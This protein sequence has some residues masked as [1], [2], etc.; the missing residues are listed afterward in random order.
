MKDEIKMKIDSTPHIVE[1]NGKKYKMIKVV[2]SDKPHNDRVI[3]RRFDEI[4]YENKLNRM[5]EDVFSRTSELK[6]QDIIKEA[7]RLLPMKDLDRIDRKLKKV[8][9]G[10][11]LHISKGCL[12]IDID[13]HDCIGIV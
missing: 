4:E 5:S 12:S 2:S 13:K 3:F 7:L 11:K 1:L 10:K 9:K 8:P 6:V